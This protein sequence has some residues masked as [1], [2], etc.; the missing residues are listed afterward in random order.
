MSFRGHHEVCRDHNFG[1]T[2]ARHHDHVAILSGQRVA[3][4]TAPRSAP[5]SA[6]RS[7]LLSVERRREYAPVSAVDPFAWVAGRVADRVAVAGG[8]TP[9]F[10]LAPD[11]SRVGRHPFRES[12]PR[13]P[14]RHHTRS[15]RPPRRR[16]LPEPSTAR[17]S[18]STQRRQDAFASLGPREARLSVLT[19]L[20]SRLGGQL[21][22]ARGGIAI[23]S[24]R[25]GR[26]DRGTRAAMKCL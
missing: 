4:T 2:S 12:L 9:G 25:I 20:P 21:S 7:A 26:R 19:A 22:M 17:F 15:P 14:H 16:D 8:A 5:V 3:T 24:R 13:R 18:A 6:P 10:T 1:A 23:A 11:P